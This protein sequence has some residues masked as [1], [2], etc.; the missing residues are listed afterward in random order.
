MTIAHY[1]VPCNEDVGGRGGIARH[2][3]K[4]SDHLDDPVGAGR[5]VGPRV[6]VDTVENG[7]FSTGNR[8]PIRGSLSRGCQ[9]GI[10]TELSG[11][12]G[13]RMS[14]GRIQQIPR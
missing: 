5:Y 10:R 12:N 11:F 9:V 4:V 13:Q 7:L 6:G 1:Y 8:M 3:T 2:Q 14:A